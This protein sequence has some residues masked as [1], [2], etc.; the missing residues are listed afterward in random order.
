M[1]IPVLCLDTCVVLDIVRDPVRNDARIHDH[2]SS[3]ALLGAVQSGELESLAANQ[4][5]LEFRD[6]MEKFS[7]MQ[8]KTSKSE[9]GKPTN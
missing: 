5:D 1:D 2:A 4:V 8:D 3:L 7:R 9:N 6:H